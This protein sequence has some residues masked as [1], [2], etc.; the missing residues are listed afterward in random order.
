MG[1]RRALGCRRRAQREARVQL[2]RH[3]DQGVE[4]PVF[5]ACR[6]QD[7]P[8]GVAGRAAPPRD[9]AAV[10]EGVL[11]AVAGTDESSAD[12]AGVVQRKP[13]MRTSVLQHGEAPA[14][15][16]HEQL[17]PVDDDDRALR[18]AEL[19]DRPQR[20]Q[21]LLRALDA[22]G[23]DDTA[24]PRPAGVRPAA[25]P[26]PSALTMSRVPCS[27]ATS[28]EHSTAPWTSH[29]SANLPVKAPT[30]AAATVGSRLRPAKPR[31]S[32][33]RIDQAPWPVYCRCLASSRSRTWSS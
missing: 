8:P 14:Y 17:L 5:D 2:G 15:A 23:H 24:R 11:V 20:H 13:E 30:T 32:T 27:T 4:H 18:S 12:D 1:R 19:T 10:S 21:P 31:L 3:P 33:C 9:M 22:H 6:Q 28:N 7:E 26:T 29:S 25:A 16:E